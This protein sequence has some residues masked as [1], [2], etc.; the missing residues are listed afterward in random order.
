VGPHNSNGTPCLVIFC[1]SF[2]R[3]PTCL[4]IGEKCLEGVGHVLEG[5]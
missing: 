1:A 5:V 4:L 2:G 3:A